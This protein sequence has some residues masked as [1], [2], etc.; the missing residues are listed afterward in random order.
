MI[1]FKKRRKK[2]AGH[3]PQKSLLLLSSYPE[4]LRQPD[5]HHPYRQDSYF[6]YLTGFVQAQSL[7][8][9]SPSGHS[10]L[11][12]KDKDPKKEVWDGLLYSK[13]KAKAKYGLEEVFYLSEI[14]KVL[15]KKFK[16]VE[17]VFYEKQELY[18]K[19]GWALL[20]K[21]TKIFNGLKRKSAFDFLR[22]F[23]QI[24]SPEEIQTIKKACSYSVQAHKELAK[25]LK[26]GIREGSLHGVFIRSIM[27]QGALREAYPSIIASGLNALILHYRENNSVCKK[28]D[29]LLVDAGAEADYYASDITR[30]YPVSGKFSKDQKQAYQLLLKLQKKLIQEV[31]PDQSLI[32]INQTMF[33]GITEILL[34]LG[35]L[36]GSLEKNFKA[37]NYK[38][39]CPHSVGHLLGLDVHDVPFK[40]TEKYL[41]KANMVL[42]IE[43]GLYIPK[44][45]QKAPK[46][47]RGLGL[48]IE[49]DILVT[50]KGSLNLTAKLP[51]EAEK[52]EELCSSK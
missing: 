8:M 34:E 19:Q 30:V 49:D 33:L 35:I 47:L 48:R 23:R 46:A 7:F 13:S 40:K 10:V 14:E 32:K 50:K 29:L 27:E 4:F 42:T 22:P 17:T 28:G 39:Y 18:K 31:R 21:K 52:I 20:D 44:N 3:L 51:K 43:P 12:I 24:K 5:V 6:Y 25:A 45:D 11:F 9:L 36:K 16:A 26:P 37:Q 38:K 41:L 1:A 2:L 15:K